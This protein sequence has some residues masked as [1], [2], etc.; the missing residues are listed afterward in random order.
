MSMTPTSP[1]SAAEAC[2]PDSVLTGLVASGERLI[3]AAT[4]IGDQEDFHV[5]RQQ[6]NAWSRG[7]AYALARD[8]VS[9]RAEQFK[10]FPWVERPLAG[11]RAALPGEV[12]AVR[13]AVAA[14]K[15]A[16]AC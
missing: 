12:Q 6:R 5:W 11:W 10:A 9:G 13:D 15:S 3:E 14:L 1:P 7:V 4:M 8:D 2:A 16:L